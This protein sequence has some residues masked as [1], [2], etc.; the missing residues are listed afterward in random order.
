[1]SRRPRFSPALQ[2]PETAYVP[3]RTPHPRETASGTGGPAPAWPPKGD[4]F[5]GEQRLA[6]LAQGVDLFNHGYFWEAHEAWEEPWQVEVR[7]SAQRLYL[8]G[9]IRLAAAALKHR[10]DEPKGVIAHATWCVAVF[11]RLA[12]QH[13]GLAEGGPG[14]PEL[15]ALARRLE[16]GTEPWDTS[17][18]GANSCLTTVLAM[19]E[20][21]AIA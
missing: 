13:P 2:F 5:R 7:E 9:L 16:Q 21:V 3:G 18:T 12:R 10:I 8:Q 20:Q 15:A 6:A 14:L 19:S 11:E 4:P 17:W 1:M